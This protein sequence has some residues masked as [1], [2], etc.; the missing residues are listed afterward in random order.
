MVLDLTST[1]SVI[2][3]APFVGAPCL[4]VGLVLFFYLHMPV[5]GV[6]VDRCIHLGAQEE[7]RRRD[8]EVK[9]QR[10]GDTEAAVDNAIV[11]EVRQVKRETKRD[12]ELDD[13]GESGTRRDEPVRLIHVWD[14]PV[15]DR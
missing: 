2:F 9:E 14:C 15:D 4:G 5:R 13:Y 10:E 3:P 6:V 8:V 11:G 1:M 12:Q 7:N